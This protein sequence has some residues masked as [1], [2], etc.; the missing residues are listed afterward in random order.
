VSRVVE[1]L[2][3]LLLVGQARVGPLA[4]ATP[5]VL[6]S[7]RP[8][9]TA[10]GPSVRSLDAPAGTRR[11]RLGDGSNDLELPFPVAAP[12]IQG[13]GGSA[14]PVRDGVLAVHAPLPSG[15]L[16]EAVA[17]RPELIV[18]GN[19]HALWREGRP[20]LAAV[21]GIRA[22]FGARPLLWA[23]RVALPY[24]LPFLAYLGI[25]LVDTTEGRLLAAAGRFLD[26]TLGDLSGEETG[27]R[28]PCDCAGCSDPSAPSLDG[29]AR[30][31][32][33]R[34]LTETR[35]AAR[36]GRLRELVE[37]RLSSE[38]ALAEMLRYADRDLASALEERTPVTGGPLRPYVL[39]E[40]L[41]RPEMTRFRARFLERYRPPAAKTILLL[42]P[43]SKTKPY[44]NSPSHRRIWA[45]LDG[46]PH[47]ER[48][49]L[50]SVSSPIGLVPRELEDVPPARQYDIPVTGDW[51]EPER[52]LVA[53]GVAHLL[54]TGQY[55]TAIVHLDPEEYGFLRAAFPP[56][57]PAVWTVPPGGGGG[58]ADRDALRAALAAELDPETAVPGGPL[59][60]VR[61]EL[62]ELAAVQFG[63]AA[64]ERL[65]AAPL[66]LA[67]RPWFQ[68]LTDGRG[69]LATVRE[70]RGL[71]QLTVAGARRLVPDPPLAVSADPTL[72]LAGDLFVPGVRAA[73][74]A[75]RAGDA[76]VV[77][78]DGALAAVGEAVLPGRLMTELDHGLAVRVRHRAHDRTDTAMSGE[79]SRANEGPVV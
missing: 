29:H 6:E 57:V 14:V 30:S 1:R 78:Q 61:E 18:L 70:E 33:A 17:S 37:T 32:Y 64:A 36:T 28:G 35:F 2:E 77:L 71:F 24:R 58:P 3:G 59:A 62:R 7:L 51:T 48:V 55:R 43:C 68:R 73:D 46:L 49:H 76:V 66:R 41:R 45:A 74:V 69:D 65:T 72:P 75:I 21:Q 25:D 34:A 39:D 50:V 15:G 20:F 16:E 54:A 31:A 11:L 53:D 5:S 42:V 40:S 12:E 23:P 38:P 13:T 8:G 67:G 19:A 44:R 47:L 26:A 60:V 4:F 79:T 63:R 22:A 56:R 27:A 52:A 9:E 10:T